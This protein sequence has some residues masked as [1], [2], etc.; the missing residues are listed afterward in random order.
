MTDPVKDAL[1]ESEA[2]AREA[3]RKQLDAVHEADRLAKQQAEAAARDPVQRQEEKVD[4]AISA[5]QSGLER[6]KK[7]PHTA[8]IVLIIAGV[9]FFTA[10]VVV[11]FL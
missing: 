7:S 8:W 4:S 11:I 1:A 10:G 6:L 2:A 5:V 9:V 3:V